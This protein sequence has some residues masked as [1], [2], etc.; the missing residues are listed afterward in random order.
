MQ[1]LISL[2]DQNLDGSVRL[3]KGQ[4]FYATDSTAR[5]LIRVKRAKSI[6]DKPDTG[7][8]NRRDMRAKD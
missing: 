2:K 3:K 6:E 8:Y 1:E 5:F 7:R 4:R